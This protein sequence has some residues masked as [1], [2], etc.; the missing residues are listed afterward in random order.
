[1]NNTMHSTT[2]R[3]RARQLWTVARNELSERRHVRTQYRVLQREL[4]SYTTRAEVDDLLGTIEGQQGVE[5]DMIRS[6][7]ANNLTQQ[8]THALAS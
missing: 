8:P 7:L 4:S 6:I 3:V 5:V 1:M 2:S